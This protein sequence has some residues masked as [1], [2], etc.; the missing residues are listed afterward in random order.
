MQSF[1]QYRKYGLAVEQQLR[2]DQEKAVTWAEKAGQ[3]SQPAHVL[4][5]AALAAVQPPPTSVPDS[6]SED[7]ID[8][9]ILGP[10]Q[11]D[12]MARTRTRFSARTALGHA[13]NGIHARD[14]KTHEGKGSLVFVVNWDGERDPL[15][16]RNISI[17]TRIWL[18][19]IVSAIAFV[20]TAASSIDTAILPQASAEFGVS[21]VVESLA[22]TGMYS[23]R[24]NRGHVS[25][26]S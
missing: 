22:A 10:G 2:Q 16:P 1:L 13:L 18:T 4:T 12:I 20:M 19:L 9:E 11:A 8:S 21:D 17:P 23:R 3:P 5:H 7:G 26:A 6:A 25:A 24:I 15:N 14:R